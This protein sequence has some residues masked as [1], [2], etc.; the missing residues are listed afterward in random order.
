MKELTRTRGWTAAVECV[1]A[2]AS[3]SNLFPAGA[4]RFMDDIARMIGYRPFP[5]IKWCWSFITPCVC[6]V[7][8]DHDVTETRLKLHT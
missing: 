2:A 7:R 3:F 8:L 1:G 6:M 4:D 5:W